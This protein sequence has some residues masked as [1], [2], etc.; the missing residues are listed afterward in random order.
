MARPLLVGTLHTI[1]LPLPTTLKSES[2]IKAVSMLGS[3]SS[4]SSSSSSTFV[5]HLLLQEEGYSVETDL[6]KKMNRFEEFLRCPSC[7]EF[8]DNPMS[9]NCGHVYCSECIRVHLDSV[10]NKM[11]TSSRCPQCPQVHE[12]LQFMP[13]RK[14]QNMIWYMI[15]FIHSLAL[16]VNNP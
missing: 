6:G 7:C 10:I 8:F 14:T 16:P 2:G 15:V 9:L 1:P 12:K 5:D 13:S 11:E 4:S 3:S